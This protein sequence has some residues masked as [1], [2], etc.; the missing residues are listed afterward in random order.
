VAEYSFTAAR[1][2]LF[3]LVERVMSRRIA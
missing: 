1:S 2:T 3:P